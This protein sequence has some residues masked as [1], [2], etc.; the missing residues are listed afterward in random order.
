MSINKGSVRHTR[1]LTPLAI[2]VLYAMGGTAGATG[3]DEP[4][5]EHAHQS[6][7]YEMV[8]AGRHEE[9]FEEAFELGDELFE[10][11]FNHL[12]GVG[13]HVGQ[14]FRFTLLPR[15]DLT[16]PGEW[17][18]HFPSRDTGP[19][20]QAC[21]ECHQQPFDDGAGSA[22][23][24]VHRDPTH[25]GQLA[26]TITRN[27]PHLFGLG[28]V[29][30]LAEEMTE[31]LR[32]A[33]ERLM[34]TVCATGGPRSKALR[35]KGVAF[36][37]ITMT[38]TSPPGARCEVD[39]DGSRI[40]G[41]ESDMVVRPLQWK[42]TDPSIRVFNRGAS[43]NE[44]G[45]QPV[46]IVGDDTDGDGDGVTNEFTIGDMTALAIYLA[47]Q[48][49]PVT[50]LELNKLGL[51]PV[52]L[53][54]TEIADIR[55]G[56]RI[57]GEIGCDGCH[58]PALKI[59][60]PVFSEPSQSPYHRD[61]VFPAGQDPQA[62]GV[63]PAFPV[64]FDLT[65]DQPDNQVEGPNGKT[66][67]LG[68]FEKDSQGQAIVR[69]YGDLKRHDMGPKLAESID[70]LG[71]GAS[72]WITK[73]LWGVGS[74]APYMHDGR[75]TTLAEAIRAHGGEGNAA[76]SAFNQ[77]ALSAKRKLIAFLN[78]LVLFKGGEG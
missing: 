60:H 12:D 46:E 42:G 54:R 5:A 16:G 50:L 3:P 4:Q 31:D 38:R 65:K 35:S 49:R 23:L 76:K 44:I 27:S 62:R 13:A 15:A 74:T 28:G 55:E 25:S 7:L 32:A 77:L 57:F 66:V 40:Q 51:L 78:N 37:R 56:R 71:T 59:R 75:A 29:Q 48:P 72:V 58:R 8:A 73:E 47:A 19:N 67:H 41:V 6:D 18:N 53:T 39:M 63:D 20:G 30:R 9:A 21:N 14:G 45:M 34:K 36:G 43:H 2:S 68:A 10:T 17:A 24:N 70:E 22:A 61:D 1:A 11:R 52:P 64:S 26:L 33:K 69:L